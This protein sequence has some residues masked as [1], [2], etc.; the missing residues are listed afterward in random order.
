MGHAHSSALVAVD[1]Q[2]SSAIPFSRGE[3]C[4]MKEFLPDFYFPTHSTTQDHKVMIAHWDKLF[5]QTKQPA[6]TE[7]GG[8]PTS[9]PMVVLFD[10]F[11]KYLFE[12]APQV[13][14]LF[15]SSMQVQGKALVRIISSIKN[16]LQSPDLLSLASE[17]AQR[18]VKYGIELSYFNVLGLTLIKT[19]K[20]C[21]EE[22]WTSETEMAWRRVYGHVALIV[23]TELAKKSA[24]AAAA[25]AGRRS[26]L[27]MTLSSSFRRQSSAAAEPGQPPKD[28]KSSSSPHHSDGQ[29]PNAKCP[30][31]GNRLK[32]LA[33]PNP[34]PHHH[35]HS[36]TSATEDDHSH[37]QHQQQ[38][39]F[40]LSSVTNWFF[41]QQH[42]QNSRA[43]RYTVNTD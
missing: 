30:M 33:K 43:A 21:S 35:N 16:M 31:S 2:A 20:S 38:G 37:H 34:E 17:L 18:H 12:M 3:L 32:D 10:N 40:G 8:G 15:R 39:S 29:N 42:H 6:G 1:D 14:P 4:T 26:S 27:F 7:S 41:G 9:S 36:R 11:Y 24:E 28:A 25:A 13:K 5:A 19:L 22:L 23:I